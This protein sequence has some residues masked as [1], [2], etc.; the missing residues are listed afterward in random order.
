MKLFAR[1][2]RKRVA[3]WYK[4]NESDK[5]WWLDNRDQIGEY[6]FSFDKKTEFNLFADYPYKLTPEQKEIFDKENPYWKDFF[7][8]R[9]SDEQ[10]LKNDCDSIWRKHNKRM[11]LLNRLETEKLYTSTESD[12]LF[13]GHFDYNPVIWEV[14]DEVGVNDP[15]YKS[16]DNYLAK[17]DI[18]KLSPQ[19]V[20]E[21]FLFWNRGER[22][23]EGTIAEAIDNGN[24]MRLFV[25]FV[26]DNNP[27][28]NE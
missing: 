9:C 11:D 27:K 20:V 24:F 1:R 13:S 15:N 17:K 18:H 26:G 7:R 2:K 8:E 12:S 19:E 4:T 14:F 25:K 6:V 5:V 23:C 21:Q 28:N 3:T 22:F 10:A 16:Y